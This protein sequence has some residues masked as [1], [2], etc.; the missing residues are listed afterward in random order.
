M[1]TRRGARLDVSQAERLLVGPA[2]GLPPL[3]LAAG[4]D[5]FLRDRVVA[6]FRAGAAAEGADL[7]RLEGDD[8][9]AEELA[10]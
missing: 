3:V 8:L 1:V 7:S 2:A 9:S 6:A 5:D 4:S 10:A